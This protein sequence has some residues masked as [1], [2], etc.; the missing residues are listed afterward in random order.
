M[1]VPL[2]WCPIRFSLTRRSGDVTGNGTVPCH[3]GLFDDDV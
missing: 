3:I 1:V 2:S